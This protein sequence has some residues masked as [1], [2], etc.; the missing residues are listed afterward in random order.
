M[1]RAVQKTAPDRITQLTTGPMTQTLRG[2]RR[3]MQYL[4]IEDLILLCRHFQC[5]IV[6]LDYR[7][8]AV[9]REARGVQKLKRSLTN[10][11][12]GKPMPRRLRASSAERSIGS[13]CERRSS[14]I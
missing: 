2:I 14:G 10:Q 8:W 7:F 3:R 13:C 5:S 9:A 11:S 4:A 6:E 12:S 1:R